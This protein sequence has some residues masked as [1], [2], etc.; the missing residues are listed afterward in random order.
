MLCYRDVIPYRTVKG[1][2]AQGDM[3]TAFFGYCAFNLGF[4]CIAVRLLHASVLIF[5]LHSS[6]D[7]LQ[8]AAVY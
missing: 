2:L 1:V 3:V 4:V 6:F 5:T 8:P 7:F